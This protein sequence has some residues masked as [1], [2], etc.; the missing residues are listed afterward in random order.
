MTTLLTRTFL[1]IVCL[2]V[3]S[4]PSV[5]GQGNKS[6]NWFLVYING[7]AGY[8]D[9]TGKVVL[10]PN[11]DNASYFYEG[12]ARVSFGRDTIITQGF[13][14]GFIDETGKVVVE[15]K[16]DVV[17]HFSGGLAAVGY[18]QT[19][20]KIEIKGRFLGYT[21]ASHTWYRW[22]FIDKN[23]KVVIE[24]RFSDVTEYSGGIAAANLV[25]Y[26]PTYESIDSKQDM[27]M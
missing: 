18:D 16:W 20:Q 15:P 19:K 26:E 25:P 11:Y 9:R 12:L 7:K 3:L 14:Q 27:I 17:S 24:N 13:S 23:G 21:S 8:I 22:G 4:V 2:I 10:E 1:L 5:F 6:D